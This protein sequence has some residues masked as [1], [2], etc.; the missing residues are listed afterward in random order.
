MA[1]YSISLVK[2]D[3]AELQKFKSDSNVT[4]IGTAV[5]IDKIESIIRPDVERYPAFFGINPM[6]L[7]SSKRSIIHY[8]AEYYLLFRSSLASKH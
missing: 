5:Y 6:E 4:L 8:W 1:E 7:G 3:E 2:K